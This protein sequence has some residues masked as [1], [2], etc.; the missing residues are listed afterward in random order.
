MGSNDKGQSHMI[1]GHGQDVTGQGH[2]I[3]IQGQRINYSVI[4]KLQTFFFSV[5]LEIL[6]NSCSLN[7]IFFI[8]YHCGKKKKSWQQL[9]I[10][11]KWK[12]KEMNEKKLKRLEIIWQEHDVFQFY[13]TERW[14]I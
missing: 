14:D 2:V 4:T 5:F 7:N 8:S 12:K 11:R 13:I 3:R 10:Y 6:K 1:Q 9:I